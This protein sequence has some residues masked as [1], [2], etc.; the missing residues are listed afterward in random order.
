[1]TQQGQ[2][3]PRPRPACPPLASAPVAHQAAARRLSLMT[4]RQ[5]TLVAIRFCLSQPACPVSGLPFSRP[6]LILASRLTWVFRVFNSDLL[7]VL[8]LC[9]DKTLDFPFLCV[10]QLCFPSCLH[11]PTLPGNWQ[12]SLQQK[13]LSREG[14]PV[15]V[16]YF[17]VAFSAVES[18]VVKLDQCLALVT[19]EP[20]YFNIK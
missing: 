7:P 4:H 20:K 2:G 19:E 6:P 9:W 11:V 12:A 15:S 10:L 14:C 3:L 16:H 17:Q 8:T 13:F 5:L 18:S 1:M